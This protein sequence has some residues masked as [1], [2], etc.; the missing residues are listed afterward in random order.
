MKVLEVYTSYNALGGPDIFWPTDESYI[1][2]DSAE[3][4]VVVY[5]IIPKDKQEDN[6]VE[7]LAWYSK[8]ALVKMLF[9]ERIPTLSGTATV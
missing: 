3:R 9:V 2:F 8:E 4:E 5:R 1:D 6:I 7:T